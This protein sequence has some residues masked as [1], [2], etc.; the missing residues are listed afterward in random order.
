MKKSLVLILSILTLQSALAQ[1]KHS[2]AM[3]EMGKTGFAPIISLDTLQKYR[4]LVAL[5]PLGKMQGEITMVD[6]VPYA[7]TTQADE[8]ASVLKNWDIKAPFLVYS[9]VKEW[10][11][12]TLSGQVNSIQE[13]EDRLEAAFVASGLDLSQPFPFRVRGTFDQMTTHIVTPRSADV[14]GYREGRNQVNFTHEKE[15]GE[16]VGFYSREGQ[17]IYTHHD[18][19]FHIH[20][21]NE[22]K[23]FTG[24]VDK[25]AGSLAGL[26]LRYPK[27]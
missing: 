10:Q 21:L 11:E 7:G 15:A 16:L 8:S 4:G 6:G 1:V 24:H 19:F 27:K 13:L 2:G 20:F 14:A 9:D 12:I 3:S 26:K 17:R 25:I 22:Q 5:G 23:T 18:S